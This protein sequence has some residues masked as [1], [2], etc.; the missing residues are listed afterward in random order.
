MKIVVDRTR[1]SSIGNCEAIAPDI[2]EI[3]DDG[4][5]KILQPDVPEERR[6]EIEQACMDCPTQA[7]SIAE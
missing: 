2:F 5:L 1:C 4:A 6:T 3:A 7:L